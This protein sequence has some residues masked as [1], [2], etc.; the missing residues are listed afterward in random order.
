MV[1]RSRLDRR[2]R[3]AIYRFMASF[4]CTLLIAGSVLGQQQGAGTR[5]NIL[6]VIL[7]DFGVD[8]LAAYGES[9]ACSIDRNPC[10]SDLDCIVPQTCDTDYPRTPSMDQL[11]AE[12]VLFRNAWAAPICRPARAAGLSGRFGFRT[13]V[14]ANRDAFNLAERTIPEALRDPSIVPGQRY[15]TAAFGKWG[16][17]LGQTD[18]NDQGFSHFAGALR[19]TIGADYF[20]WNRTVNGQTSACFVGSAACPTVAYATT[21][22]VNDAI[23]W[24]SDQTE[25]WFVWFSFNAPHSPFHIPPHELVSLGT[26]ARLPTDASSQTRPLGTWCRGADRR[27]CYLAMIEAADTELA[28]LLAAVPANTMVILL[29]DNGT[30]RMTTALPFISEHAK[31]TVYEGGINVPFIIRAPDR[32][33]QGAESP[34]LIH[35]V[36]LFTTVVELAGGMVPA[37]EPLDSL[38]LLPL[39]ADSNLPLRT[40]NFSQSNAA[41]T[42]RDNRFKLIRRQSSE[43]FYDLEGAP[44]AVP[45]DPF[46]QSN[47]LLGELTS[48]QQTALD[49]LRA[50]MDNLLNVTENTTL[51]QRDH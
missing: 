21:V 23:D 32:T 6:V 39:I 22:N 33:S 1:K 13:G 17:G 43:E 18:P 10:V 37:D 34:A 2:A 26:L 4:A 45:G 3:R 42:T 9:G 11:A 35:I 41:L 19:A 28:R 16:L 51:F 50:E 31:G 46:E 7:D 29:G 24:I 38:S 27:V 49:R 14:T 30:P 15:A 47:L 48:A 5:P 25:P 20:N 40:I 44:P 12:G 8:M 36:D